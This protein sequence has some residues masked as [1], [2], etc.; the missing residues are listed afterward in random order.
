MWSKV[1]QFFLCVL[2]FIVNGCGNKSISSNVFHKKTSLVTVFVKGNPLNLIEGSQNESRSFITLTNMGSFDQ[3]NLASVTQFTERDLVVEKTDVASVEEG[4]E[5][6]KED[7]SENNEDMMY[8][9]SKEGK[10]F[11][12]S[13]PHLN[14]DLSFGEKLGKLE[15][16][17]VKVSGIDY[18]VK[19]IHY[20]L[21][22]TSDAFSILAETADDESGKVLLA[23][24][25]VKKSKPREIGKTY[26]LFKY[27]YGPGIKI[28][29]D[30]RTD[31]E[32]NICGK[33]APAVEKAYRSGISK[34][35]QA[36]AGRTKIAVKTLKTYPP[37]SDLNNHCIYTV[38]NYQTNPNNKVSTLGTTYNTAD[39]SKGVIIDSDVMIWVK[40]NEKFGTSFENAKYLNKAVAHEVGHWLG[41][42]HQFDERF[43]SIMSYDDEIDYVTDY[44]EAAIAELYPLQ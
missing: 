2:I 1:N 29:W 9:F 27:L 33:Q 8:S 26:S 5:A 10:Q 20:S 11:I 28:P 14:V 34:W 3:Y 42:H 18:R 41:L 6:P 44:D 15:L 38:K 22:N 19:S 24:T 12:Y 36:L 13:N 25:F 43:S 32:L 35:D 40:E 21:K 4:N 37:F 16:N 23:F 31:L 7:E 39:F 30:E 17:G